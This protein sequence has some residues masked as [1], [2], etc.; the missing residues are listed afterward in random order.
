MEKLDRD[1]FA[2]EKVYDKVAALGVK[3]VRLQSGWQKTEKEKGKYDFAWLDSQVDNL[4]QRGIQPWVCLCY[5]NALYDELAK[6]Y[7]GAVGCTPVHNAEAY[8]AWCRYVQA[9]AAHFAGRVTWYEIWNEAEGGWTWRPEPNA[10]EYAAF[11]IR[12]AQALKAGD[13]TVKIITGSHYQNSMEFFSQE[14]AHG[15]LTVSDAVTFHSY[16]YDERISIMKAKAFRN[17]SAACGREVEIIQGESGSQSQSGGN[18]ALWEYRTDAQMQAKQIMR[19]VVGDLLCD[20]KFTSIFSAVDMA[21]NLD[22]KAGKPITTCGYFGL[23]GADFDPTT[24]QLVGD[25]HE[26]PSYYGYAS[27]CSVFREKITPCDLPVI[28]MP[29]NSMRIGGTDVPTEK[30][31]YGGFVRPGGAKA[32]VYWAATDLVT[33]KDFEST[34]SFE[35]Y[36]GTNNV[37]LIDPRDGSVYEIPDSVMSSSDGKLFSFKN[38]PVK[39]YPLIIAMDDFEKAE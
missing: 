14:F 3:W 33:Q 12:T 17:L 25:Y 27:L 21:E 20:V 22:A 1:A 32:F 4:L 5:G 30:L 16:Q 39:D 18:G 6:Q 37:R 2:P 24:G 34:V 31:V 38:M 19:H 11:C 7:V 36:C 26:K 35:L 23:L 15:T 8:D 9:T 10:A 29:Q 13:P 28:F